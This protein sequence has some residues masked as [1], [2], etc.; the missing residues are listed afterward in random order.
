MSFLIDP[1]WLYANGRVLAEIPDERAGKALGAATVG[2][3]LTISIGL[4]L[5]RPWTGW[6]WRAC[7][8]EDGRDWMLNS[9]V[10][11][12]DHKRAGTGT[13][14]VSALVFATYPLWLWLGWRQGRR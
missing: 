10:F 2:T 4:Y 7:R 14:V 5:N 1:P 11:R 8:A 6:L 9:G 12:F 13:H 3:F